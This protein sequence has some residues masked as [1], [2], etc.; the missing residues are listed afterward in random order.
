MS[1]ALPHFKQVFRA[2]DNR[3]QD[4][5]VKVEVGSG[6]RRLRVLITL[7][8]SVS[9][10]PL[11]NRWW[12]LIFE[13]PGKWCKWQWIRKQTQIIVGISISSVTL[14]YA[15]LVRSWWPESYCGL[16]IQFWLR[17]LIICILC[18]IFQLHA[19]RST[20]YSASENLSTQRTP[21]CSQ[22]IGRR[23]A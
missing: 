22:C 18:W 20:S 9:S 14:Y 7:D 15:S 11:V 4:I 3:Y 10:C 5:M 17:P 16:P 2:H 21:L 8:C 1:I 23:R 19:L 12:Y 6:M 13:A